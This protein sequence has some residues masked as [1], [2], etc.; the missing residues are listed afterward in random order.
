MEKRSKFLRSISLTSI[1]MSCKYCLLV[2]RD[3]I[4]L[5]KVKNICKRNFEYEKVH[6]PCLVVYIV[7]ETGPGTS[8]MSRGLYL[9]R[10]PS[11]PQP[12]F[13]NTLFL[14]Q[15]FNTPSHPKSPVRCDSLGPTFVSLRG[16]Y[17]N[18]YF[19]LVKIVFISFVFLKNRRRFGTS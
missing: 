11:P 12:F 16:V 3:R 9:R 2:H 7:R 14:V 6:V 13:R 4:S 17:W 15:E 8:F 5:E 18:F 10:S 19:L 1:F